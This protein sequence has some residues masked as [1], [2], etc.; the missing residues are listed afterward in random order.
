MEENQN[1]V[2]EPKN[3]VQNT[4]K[5]FLTSIKVFLS[6]LLDIREGTNIEETI[7][8]IKNGIAVKSHTAWILIFSIIIGSIGLN[9]SS[10]A[11]VI[12]AML[13][14]P[15]MGPILGVGLSIGTNDVL[16]L[17]KSFKHLGIMVGLS[18][19]SSFIFFSI[20]LFQ[21]ATP[22]LIA[23][24]QPDV[25]DVL[26][27]LSGGLA[28]IVALSRRNEMTNTVAGIAIATALMPPL[29]TAGFGLATWNFKFFGG[30]MFL[31]SINATFI[32]LSTFVVVK[33]LRFPV[34][35]YI[36]SAKGKRVARLASLIALVVFSFSIYLFY[37]LIQ[38]KQYNKNARSFI[39]EIKNNTGAGIISNEISFEKKTIKL[40]ILGKNIEYD[41]LQ[42]WKSKLAQFNLAGTKIEIHQDDETSKLLSEINLIK[43]SYIK[44]QEQMATKDELI[45]E[46]ESEIKRL[47]SELNQILQKQI[48]FAQISEEAKINYTGLKKI[49]FYQLISTDFKK[50]DTV[51]VFQFTWYPTVTNTAYQEA[52]LKKWLETR[53]N[54]KHLKV[55]STN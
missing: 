53:L 51:P 55:E 1:K 48:P 18:L 25:R 31:F 43:G 41:A 24:T 4:F 20:P 30:A 23:R 38:K 46:K 29:C 17:K 54:I 27:A 10:P 39:T 3:D 12:G 2:E 14:S 40:V 32:A 26:I 19:L 22:E 5:S 33:S 11:V 36:D 47:T 21:D 50:T 7:N 28:L 34:V 49:N 15:L 8:K 9:T 16:T 45:Q 13:I 42:T 52:K 37:G 6:D 35:D 44:N